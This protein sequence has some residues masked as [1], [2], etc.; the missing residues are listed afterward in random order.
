MLLQQPCKGV[1]QGSIF[2]PLLY[3]VNTADMTKLASFQQKFHE[4]LSHNPNLLDFI[5]SLPS[6]FDPYLRQPPLPAADSGLGTLCS[7]CVK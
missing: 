4:N 5:M 2:S 3:T 1:P 6:F 7:Y